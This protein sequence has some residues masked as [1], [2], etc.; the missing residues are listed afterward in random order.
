MYWVFLH[1]DSN[2]TCDLSTVQWFYAQELTELILEGQTD[3]SWMQI[4]Y[5]TE[6]QRDRD[7]Q[8]LR[9]EVNKMQTAYNLRNT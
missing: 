2:T 9:Q 3:K 6:E 1:D 5:R 8:F 4:I 7:L